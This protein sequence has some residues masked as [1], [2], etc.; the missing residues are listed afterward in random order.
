MVEVLVGC[1]GGCV[2][3]CSQFYFS[4][5]GRDTPRTGEPTGGSGQGIVYHKPRMI[6]VTI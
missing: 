1:V 6:A 5:C 3:L 4:I 2:M